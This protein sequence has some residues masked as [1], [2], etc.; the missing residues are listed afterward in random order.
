MFLYQ[1]FQYYTIYTLCC[2][3]LLATVL[4]YLEKGFLM[5]YELLKFHEDSYF[6]AKL[7]ATITIQLH[8]L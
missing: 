4:R 3:P 7:Q 1:F 8:V 5:L 2:L 6:V